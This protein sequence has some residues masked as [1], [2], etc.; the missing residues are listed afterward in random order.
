MSN[1]NKSRP[2]KFFIPYNDR[3]NASKVRCIDAD[4]TNIGLI[5]ID[6]ALELAYSKELDLVQIS[7][8]GKEG[9]PVCKIINFGKFKFEFLKKQKE[10]A[11]KQ[12]ESMIKVKE[13]KFRPS[14]DDNDLRVKANKVNEFIS[15]GD[16][17]KIGITFKGREL[18]HKE[19]AYETLTKFIGYVNNAQLVGDPVLMGRVLTVVL[20]K[21]KL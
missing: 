2:A 19:V 8:G 7:D 1:F 16:K 3:I 5:D 14:T 6:K 17:V 11:K 12:R 21:K 18:A 15:E 4:D 20:E 9:I 10:T 13:I